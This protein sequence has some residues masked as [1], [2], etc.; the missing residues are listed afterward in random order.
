M[1]KHALWLIP[2]QLAVGFGFLWL[3]VKMVRAV[4]VG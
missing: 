3:V 2:L 1:F 4:W